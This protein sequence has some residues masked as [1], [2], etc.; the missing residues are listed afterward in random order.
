[1][2]TILSRC[3]FSHIFCDL[4][5]RNDCYDDNSVI[6]CLNH[7]T[8]LKF[9]E[10]E[11]PLLLSLA[12]GRQF[13]GESLDE[14]AEKLFQNHPQLQIILY[15]R[16]SIGSVIL[17]RNRPSLTVPAAKTEV[18]STVG[19][20]DSIG[21]SWLCMYLWG[22]SLDHAAEIASRVSAFM[23]AH[24]EVIPKYRIQEFLIK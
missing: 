12:C 2:E 17:E 20:G 23:V 14:V 11:N 19:A 3:E 24:K 9:S 16:G 21:A 18:V 1:M 4:N 7:A 5:L 8:I 22:H 6:N 15:T 13:S 10:E